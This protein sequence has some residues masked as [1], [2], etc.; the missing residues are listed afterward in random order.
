MAIEIGRSGVVK[1]GTSASD[2]AAVGSVRSFSIE[3]SADTI[4]TSVMGDTART[5]VKGFT[6]ATVS[7]EAYWDELDAQQLLMDAGDTVFFEVQPT[8]ACTSG[9]D[10]KHYTGSG[11]VTSKSIN[12]PFDGVVEASFSIQVSGAVAEVEV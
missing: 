2:E 4:E 8:G 10:T 6:T 12:A 5:Y 7:I 11:I 1:I 3:E 9:D